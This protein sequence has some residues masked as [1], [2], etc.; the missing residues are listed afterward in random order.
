MT[1]P[2]SASGPIV[3]Q[4][5]SSDE[6]R[7]LAESIAPLLVPGDVLVLAGDLGAGKTTFV[8]GLAKGLGIVERVT[9]PTFILMK[10]YPGGRF[11]L[12]HLDVYRLGW[13]QEVIDLGID[14]FLDPSYVVA[15]E[16]GDRVEPLLPQEHLNVDITHDEAD[17]RTIRF[18]GK[19][20]QWEARMDSLRKLA[21]EL[22]AARRNNDPILGEEFQPD[23]GA[24][25]GR[26]N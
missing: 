9:S 20:R 12:M 22:V 25:S 24:E 17:R 14:E 19:G 6:S 26:N 13:V 5:R 16:W 2:A 11:P 3:V 10:E 15:V 8:Q 1:K 7:R 4:T 23:N 18:S 21:E